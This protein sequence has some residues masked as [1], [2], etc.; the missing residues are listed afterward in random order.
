MD[1]STFWKGRLERVYWVKGKFA[2]QPDRRFIKAP[3]DLL[4]LDGEMYVVPASASIGGAGKGEHN[5][6][7]GVDEGDELNTVYSGGWYD[8][9]NDVFLEEYQLGDW[10]GNND[11]WMRVHQFGLV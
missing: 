3:V 10:N 8:T 2:D 1:E 6:I 11:T 7:T 5:G 4:K 9:K